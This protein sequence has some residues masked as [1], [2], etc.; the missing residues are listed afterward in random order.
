MCDQKDKGLNA[1]ELSELQKQKDIQDYRSALLEGDK[2][3]VQ[4][5]DK[6][7]MALSG[8]AIG[9]S[10]TFL[11]TIGDFNTLERPCLLLLAWGLWG[12][13]IVSV[14]TSH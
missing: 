13:S 12:F 10:F 7:V 4:E 1:V 6:A 3:S 5:Y 11:K 14:L 8:G 2:A 9:I